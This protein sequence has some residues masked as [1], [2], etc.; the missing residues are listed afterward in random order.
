[1]EIVINAA[2]GGQNISQEIITPL[3]RRLRKKLKENFE[4]YIQV[5]LVRIRI[6]LLFNGDLTSYYQK[7]GL[8]QP[9]Y[10]NKK[11]EYRLN[12]CF[13]TNIWQEDQ[14]ENLEIFFSILRLNVA[15]SISL[16]ASKLKKIKVEF[17]QDER[18]YIFDDTLNSFL[19]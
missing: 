9:I 6:T 8:Y 14:K 12:I 13:N 3:V 2:Y 5:G 15:E 7:T 11:E 19:E 1:M 18:I 16:L 17:N 4:P 10:Y